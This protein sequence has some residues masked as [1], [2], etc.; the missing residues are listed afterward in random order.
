MAK[1]GVHCET[2]TIYEELAMKKSPVPHSAYQI[3][4]D[5]FL[6]VGSFAK[7]GKTMAA[8]K[9]QSTAESANAF[10]H[11]KVE[12]PDLSAQLSGATETLGQVSDYALHTDVKH[13]VDDVSAF[14]RK[15]PVAALISVVAVGAMFSSLMM[16]NSSQVA[17]NAAK[18]SKVITRKAKAKAKKSKSAAIPRRKAN[19][20]TQAHA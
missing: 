17:K 20:T 10:V 8:S 11:T 13:M 14:A 18:P 7:L 3:L 12:M 6:L 1:G 19:G 9:M 5:V 16:R 4:E 2:H 15:H